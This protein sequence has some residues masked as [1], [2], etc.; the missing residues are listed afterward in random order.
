[1]PDWN[2]TVDDCTHVAVHVQADTTDDAIN[3]VFIFLPAVEN[4]SEVF[5]VPGT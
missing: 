3:P 4:H 2:A 1:M 5:L